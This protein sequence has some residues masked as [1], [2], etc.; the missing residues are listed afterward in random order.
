MQY[1]DLTYSLHRLR[2]NIPIYVQQLIT[3]TAGRTLLIFLVFYLLLVQ[4]CRHAFYRDPTSAFFD[5]SRAYERIY[6]L[7]RQQQAVSFIQAANI[8]VEEH[9]HPASKVRMCLGIATVERPGEQY[10]RP[11]FGSLMEGLTEDERKHIHTVVLI[12]HT[13]PQRHPIYHEPWLENLSDKVL[14]YNMSNEDQFE[15]L[16]KW[17]RH[18]DFRRK[19]I[20]DYTFLLETCIQSGAAWV[21]MVED[22]TLA[23][24]GWY[25][26]TMAALDVAD[27]KS[28]D[29]LYL[30]LFFTEQFF[31]WNSE[32]W[33]TYLLSS[34][35][36]VAAIAAL[37]M[38]LRRLRYHTAISNWTIYTACFVCTPACIL[39]YFMAGRLSMRPLPSGVHE[40]PN[41]GCCAQGMVF[42]SPAAT[43]V[44]AKLKEKELGFVDMILEEWA[45]EEKLT[46]FAVIPSLLQHV[47][48]HSSKGDDFTSAQPMSVAERIFNFGF[49]LY[50]QRGERVVHPTTNG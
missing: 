11:A 36:I 16:V 21:A 18:K 45:N 31:G 42:S 23:V 40:M 7:Q 32:F 50:E 10:I 19:V 9:R 33:P 43:R 49:E 17:E 13:D 20:F 41:F 6:S 8:S 35:S 12:G 14:T 2:T 37:L 46:R 30:R 38:G 47:G 1:L 28:T 39:L 34:L 5:P 44:A 29:W 15:L 48:G 24:K 22:D 25:P 3:T 4:A 26:R 27:S